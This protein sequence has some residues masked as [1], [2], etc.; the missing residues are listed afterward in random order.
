MILYA[1]TIFVSAFLLFLIQPIIAK[2]ILPWFGGTAAVWTT[3]LVFFQFALLAGYFYSD[4]LTRKLA[5]RTQVMIH[6]ALVVVALFLLPIIPDAAW[7]PLGDESPS[8]RILL[9]LGAT[10]GLPY[11]LLATTSPLVQ[12]WFARSYPGA[13]PYR[14]FALSNLAS[15]LALLGYPFLFERWIATREQAIGW[16]IGFGVFALLIAASAW[17]GIKSAAASSE[18]R[19]ERFD[20]EIPP[21]AL[22]EKLE[23]IVLAALGSVLLLAISNHLTQ[24]ISSIPLMWVVPLSI[25]LITFI[26]CFDG[27][28]W[29]RRAWFLPLLAIAIVAMAWMLADSRMHFQLYWQIA[30]FSA[31]LF[32]ACMFCH[33]ELVEKKPHPKHLT[34][35]YLMVSVGGAVGAVLVGLVAPITLPAYFELEIALV[36]LALTASYLLW[37]TAPIGLTAVAVGVS[38]FAT[39]AAGFTI[40]Q[41]KEDV[42]VMTRNF[43][44]TLRVKQYDPPA[45]ENRRRSLIHGAILHGDQYLDPPYNKSATTY[46]KTKSGI[47]RTLL[48]KEKLLAAPLKVGVIG[49]G[50]GTLATYGNKGD[51]YRFYDINPEVVTIAKRDFTYLRDTDATVEIALGDARL[52]LE[53]EPL[54]NFDVL[55]IDA[56]SSDSIPVHLITLEAVIAYERHM[57]PNGVIAFHTSNRFLDLKP[58]IEKIAKQRGLNVAWVRDTY[59]DGGTSSDWVLLTKDRT[60]VLKAEIVEATEPINPQPDWRLWTDDFNN[61]LQVLR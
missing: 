48:L 26:L 24:N 20:D 37:R 35:F 22:G 4:W 34:T 58:V 29:Y 51:I 52:N 50:A 2:Q 10:I 45:V 17:L 41:F 49:L 61:L 12:A 30:V 8:L 53:R 14:L 28:G 31:G 25:Y 54:Q 40:R 38:L 56:F 46:Y 23:W 21:P 43:Y 60:F 19:D 7:K 36:A 15:M 55:A 1:L 3:C 13:S 32:V 42:V 33:G 44:G 9:L 27:K 59:E 16:S 18:S 47:G 57:K 5:L 11:F 39:G 6:L